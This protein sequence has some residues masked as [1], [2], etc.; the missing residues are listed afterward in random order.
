[1]ERIIS[2]D[3][4]KDVTQA[5]IVKDTNDTKDMVQFLQARNPFDD[6]KD[7]RNIT[8]GCTVPATVNADSAEKVGSA[9]LQ[10][11]EG[12][13]II[14]F[15]FKKKAQAITMDVKESVK[16]CSE[17]IHIDA[18]LLFQRLIT[19]GTRCSDLRQLMSYELSSYPT[20]MFDSKTM[21]KTAN[22]A[23]LADAMW[24]EDLDSPAPTGDIHYILDGGALLHRIPWTRG[25]TWDR[26][27]QDYCRYVSSRYGRAT[28]V[29]DGYTDSSST[30]DCAQ[31]RRNNGIVGVRVH[32]AVDMKLEIKKEVF[33]ANKENKQHF[34]HLLGE[35][36]E[37]T[38]CH[39]I[40]AKGDADLPIVQA[41]VE[42]AARCDS[43]LVGDDTDL[44]VLLCYHGK[45]TSNQLFFKP[46]PKSHAKKRPR[47][48]NIQTTRAALGN[49][50][51]ENIL[52][53]HAILGCDTTSRLHGLGKSLSLTRIK[54][55]VFYKQ[56]Q[57]FMKPE[58][59][60]ESIIAAGEIAVVLLYNAA[61]LEGETIDELRYKRFCEKAT[62]STTSVQP[63]VLPPTSAALRNH[64]LRV[65]H[66]VQMWCGVDNLH[67]EDWGW[68]IIIG[69][70][71]PLTSSK[72]PAPQELL[73]VIRC[74]CKTGCQTLR[75]TCHKNG[76]DCTTACGECR[77]I[78]ANMLIEQL[79]ELNEDELN[80]DSNEH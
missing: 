43:I 68:K 67:P 19:V 35:R 69:R 10:S 51:C 57:V 65:Y 72:D 18:N 73:K 79:E 17:D 61:A 8:T 54:N 39:V 38:G 5:R 28:V 25:H 13:R 80:I 55:D 75:C 27:L 33:L 6:L 64:S 48:W 2:S 58:M 56:A 52:F 11:M 34:L 62:S 29:F 71:L 46:E 9:I 41:A 23:T 70:M 63:H 15:V 74:S 4:H 59:T 1:M 22:K 40:H 49:A 76:L 20:A 77:G 78:C 32:F 16:V 44:L 42:S 12:K 45:N 30:K 3:Q 14:D 60:A 37:R 36:L 24:S 21:M 53:I 26:I 7:L 47:T 66:Q 50:V 31:I